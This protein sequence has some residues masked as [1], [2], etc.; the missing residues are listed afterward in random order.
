VAVAATSLL[1]ACG[2]PAAPPATSL[3]MAVAPPE[4]KPAES[5]TAPATA[6]TDESSA[7]PEESGGDPLIG[8]DG[9]RVDLAVDPLE[10]W[11]L[12]GPFGTTE[13]YLAAR[14]DDAVGEGCSPSNGPPSVAPKTLPKR[15][16]L[17]AIKLFRRKTGDSC[18]PTEHCYIA[19]QTVEGWW[20]GERMC[21]GRIEGGRAITTADSTLRWVRLAQGDAAVVEY[22]VTA[23]STKTSRMEEQIRWLRLCGVGSS[24]KPSCTRPIILSCTDVDG[25]PDEATFTIVDGKVSLASKSK[26]DEACDGS[27]AFLVGTFA[28][29][30]P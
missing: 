29:A 1:L 30:F 23:R 26:H 22:T 8:L 24:G 16:R 3:P 14:E 10:P 15:E 4:P 17:L 20:V 18:D 5:A 13:A 2:P 11:S 27:E 6:E 19:V 9:L 21:A 7:E 12:E 28:V 25:A